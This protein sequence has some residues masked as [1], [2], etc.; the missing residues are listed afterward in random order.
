MNEI[1]NLDI[2]L[3][4]ISTLAL[5]LLVFFLFLQTKKVYATNVYVTLCGRNE[6]G[7]EIPLMEFKLKSHL[8]ARKGSAEAHV[9]HE[10][11][12]TQSLFQSI[13]KNESIDG[14]I[15]DPSILLQVTREID[16]KS[17]KSRYVHGKVET[18]VLSDYRP[19]IYSKWR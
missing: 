10:I 18:V 11:E 7:T 12:H 13:I 16:I 5:C 9:K 15:I 2:A 14:I 19:Y 3:G 17:I 6:I 4:A 8:Y 1:L